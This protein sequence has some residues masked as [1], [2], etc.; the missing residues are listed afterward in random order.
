M[1]PYEKLRNLS[2]EDLASIIVYVRTLAP[3]RNVLPKTEIIFPVKYLIRNAPQ[4][5]TAAG[6]QS[7]TRAIRCNGA[8]TW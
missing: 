7:R 4:P 5:V 2:D 8:N 6:E 1:M 3:V